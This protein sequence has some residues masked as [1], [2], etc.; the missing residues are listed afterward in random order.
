M[1]AT[2]L[3]LIYGVAVVASSLF[4]GLLPSLVSLTH[5]RMQLVLSF[6]G[7][8]MLGVGLLHLL[9]HSAAELG[10]LDAS[11]TWALGGLLGMFF[12]IRTFHFHE[13]GVA[14]PELG[15]EPACGP[16]DHAHGHAHDHA[17]GHAH[18]HG[19]HHG[20]H[21][22]AGQAGISPWGWVGVACGLSLHT[23]LDGVALAAAVLAEMHHAESATWP[24]FA[25]VLAIMLHKP[26]DALS[27]TT[28]MHA[29]G[30]SRRAQQT[31]NAGFALMCPLGALAFVLFL[32]QVG[33][34]QHVVLGVALALS[35][36]I[37]LCI[38]LSDLL[39]E[40]QFHHHDRFKLS[41]A[42]LLGVC[43]A[44]AIR[45]VEPPHAHGH[46]GHDH[47]QHAHD[48]HP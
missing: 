26:L 45:F 22:N 34:N 11:V 21:S 38:S 8:L 29:R 20:H 16:D 32:S 42:L 35:A 30:W 47:A 25:I 7:G 15:D 23:F 5:L 24:G 28:L 18:G 31:V 41:A 3:I 12:L 27:I 19:H 39:P 36:G 17:H 37:F 6:V 14:S 46:T 33:P 10:S 13:H 2:L 48:H 44:Y 1:T 4:G 40:V 9:P 43:C